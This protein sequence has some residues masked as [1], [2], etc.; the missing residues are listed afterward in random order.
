MPQRHDHGLPRG[1]DTLVNADLHLREV[2]LLKS[3]LSPA[4]SSCV[5]RKSIWNAA[6]V[7]KPFDVAVRRDPFTT[8]LLSTWWK[9]GAANEWELVD[10][11]ASL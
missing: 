2:D 6:I 5:W 9:E 10:V 7:L 8:S 11:P 1:K 3:D 4:S